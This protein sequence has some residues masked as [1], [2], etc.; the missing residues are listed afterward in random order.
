MAD[1]MLHYLN[2]MNKELTPTGAGGSLVWR[3][4]SCDPPACL[5]MG[6]ELLIGQMVSSAIYVCV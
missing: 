2:V 5:D 3:Y 6:G 1:E 4:M